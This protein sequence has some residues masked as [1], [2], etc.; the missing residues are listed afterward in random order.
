MRREERDGYIAE[1]SR[2][3]GAENVFPAA[4]REAGAMRVDFEI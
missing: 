3:F 1:M 4:V 2:V